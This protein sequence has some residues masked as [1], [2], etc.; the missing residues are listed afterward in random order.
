MAEPK[1]VGLISSNEET[2]M[3]DLEVAFECKTLK[4]RHEETHIHSPILLPHVSSKILAK[5]IKFCKYHVE[6]RKSSQEMHATFDEEIKAW[7][8]DIKAWHAKFVNVNI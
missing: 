7:D 1:L 5:V 3:V 4:K 6:K 8:D 2:F